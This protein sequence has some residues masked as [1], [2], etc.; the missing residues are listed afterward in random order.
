MNREL[1]L[2]R[3]FVDLAD[4][5]SAYFDPLDLFARLG[6][7][8]VALL[9]VDAVGVVMAVARGTLRTMAA[10]ADDLGALEALQVRRDEGPSVDCYRSGEQVVAEDLRADGRWP[11]YAAHALEA[12]YLAVHALPL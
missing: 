4:T 10:S 7:H 5:L 9:A 2:T 12:G 6:G 1:R 3:A 8:C 11:A